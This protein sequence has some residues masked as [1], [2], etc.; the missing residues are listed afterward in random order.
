VGVVSGFV[1]VGLSFVDE[2]GGVRRFGFA[3]EQGRV[4]E[5]RRL[6]SLMRERVSLMGLSVGLIRERVS[7]MG[8][9]VGLIRERVSLMR[10]PVSSTRDPNEPH[11][12]A[13]EAH[14]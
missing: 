5:T 13:Y 1:G 14:S 6:F 4:S 10:W 7:L 12:W 11:S 9:S 8:L 2:W 3:P